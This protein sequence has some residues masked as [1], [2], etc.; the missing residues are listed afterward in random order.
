MQ[1]AL[2]PARGAA[3]RRLA[4]LQSR[5][6]RACAR[7]R[8]RTRCR[9]LGQREGPGSGFVEERRRLEARL[10]GAVGADR[11][12]RPGAGGDRGA[13][14][15]ARTASLESGRAALADAERRA[16][17]LRVQTVGWP[18]RSIAGSGCGHDAEGRRRPGDR[19]AAERAPDAGAPPADRAEDEARA[20][21]LDATGRPRTSRAAEALRAAGRRAAP[22]GGAGPGRGRGR[23][24]AEHGERQSALEARQPALAAR[25]AELRARARRRSARL[26]QA[27]AKLELRHQEAAMR[28]TGIEERVAER[29]RDVALGQVV[30]TTTCGR[31]SATS[32]RRGPRSCAASSSAWARSTSPRSRSPRSFKKRFDFLDDAEERPRVGGRAARGGDREDQQ[33][34]A[35]ALPRDVRRGQR[36]FQ[37]VFPRLLRRRPRAPGAHRR[38]ATCSRP[39]SRSSRSRRARRSARTIELLSGG[40][41]ALTAVALHLRHLP[42]QAVAVLRARR[43]R[44][45]ARR[46][47]R[48]SLQRDR[49]AR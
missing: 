39:A 35:Q 6:R 13:R 46:G 11:G 42:H 9:L 27:A 14:R 18:T 25:E 8:T 48:R 43:G 21:R 49:S 30:T 24:R 19:A 12:S 45:A 23:G 1:A 44:R 31:C 34:L 38:G 10:G 5:A 32:R 26:A 28:R 36:E 4:D 2:A 20:T 37:E 47:Q 3:S 22:R 29:Y 17:D 40:E 16:G 33:D 7:V 15:E 41:K